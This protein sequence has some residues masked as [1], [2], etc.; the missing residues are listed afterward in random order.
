MCMH[1]SLDEYGRI[2]L[3]DPLLLGVHYGGGKHAILLKD[4]ETFAKVRY[5]FHFWLLPG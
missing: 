4:S 3:R 2:V 5:S 1:S